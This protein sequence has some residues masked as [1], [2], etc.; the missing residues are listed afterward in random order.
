VSSPA[1]ISP[2]EFFRADIRAGLV[3]A[4]DEFPEAR[5][6]AY[7]LLIDFGPREAGDIC[8]VIGMS[9]QIPTKAVTCRSVPGQP[10]MV[11]VRY[12]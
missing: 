5:K 4:A 2:D 7:K 1:E 9:W 3:I 6:P 8:D 10:A 11:L 12:R